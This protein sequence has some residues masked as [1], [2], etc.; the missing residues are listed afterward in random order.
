MIEV[1]LTL[2]WISTEVSLGELIDVMDE[3]SPEEVCYLR[4]ILSDVGTGIPT[5][6]YFEPRE[7]KPVH[8]S[9]P[10]ELPLVRM[11]VLDHIEGLL[12]CGKDTPRGITH[13]RLIEAVDLIETI[14]VDVPSVGVS[15]PQLLVASSGRG[16]LI[17]GVS[18]AGEVG[19]KVAVVVGARVWSIIP[20]Q[21]R[22]CILPKAIAEGRV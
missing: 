3:V 22:V 4:V 21:R 2:G 10:S 15:M 13:C 7:G 1:Y 5:C 8:R 6:V 12:P 17:L 9:S 16:I 11:S 19:G 14:P 18:H 20:V